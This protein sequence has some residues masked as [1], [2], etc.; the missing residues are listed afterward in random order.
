MNRY[1]VAYDLHT[2]GNDYL[3]LKIILKTKY[4]GERILES[5]WVIKTTE[6][7]KEVYDFLENYIDDNDEIFV[8]ILAGWEGTSKLNSKINEWVFKK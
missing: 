5:V 3:G 1:V 7:S 4:R 6:T 2:P 8:N